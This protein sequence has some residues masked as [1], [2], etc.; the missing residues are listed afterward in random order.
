MS[1]LL[2][3][4][5]EEEL[6]V[7]CR[8]PQL[9]QGYDSVLPI[10]PKGL[11]LVG[12]DAAKCDG[13]PPTGQI[14]SSDL[15]SALLQC[16]GIFIN[17]APQ[18]ALKAE[19]YWKALDLA[20]KNDKPVTIT[21][22]LRA[23]LEEKGYMA[24]PDSVKVT[25][26]SVED[27][28]ATVLE[29]LY[30][31]PVPIITVLGVGDK[32]NKFDLQLG[33]A[34]FFKKAGYNVSLLGTKEYTSLFGF[35]PLPQFLFEGG[36]QKEKILQFNHFVYKL[37]MET[38]PDIIIVGCPGAIMPN[39]PFKFDDYGEL[40]FVIGNALNADISVL[41]LYAM[42]YNNQAL[43][44]LHSLCKYRHNAN[45]KR[46]NL[47]CKRMVMDQATLN[48]RYVTL[49]QEFIK[50]EIIPPIP[51][52]EMELYVGLSE[53]EMDRLGASIEAELLQNI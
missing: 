36:C 49:N 1:K 5:Y 53:G 25:G 45:V 31:I 17:Y 21:E 51:A 3:Y 7:F 46:L 16:E 18:S 9:V 29:K 35:M 15:E 8:F 13:G 38:H 2:V 11:G 4:P 12:Q 42:S 24:F 23:F 19:S 44:H 48:Y 52:G 10:S 41:S 34:D 6:N 22:S 33:L 14:V 30:E 28:L 40:A 20:L 37:S 43:E 39:N 27:T 47:A 26:Y 32:S 50:K